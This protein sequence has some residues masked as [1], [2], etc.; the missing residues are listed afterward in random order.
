MSCATQTYNLGV[1]NVLFGAER[2]QKHCIFTVKDTASSLNNKYIVMHAPVTNA[3]HYFWFNTGAGADP[4]VP[5]A[6]GHEVTITANA[7]ASAVATALQGVIDPLAFCSATVS[8]NEVEVTYTTYGYAYN[9]RDGFTTNATGFTIQTPVFGSTQVDL[10]A[11]DGEIS[12]SA[13]PEYLA[14]PDPRYGA[15]N[16]VDLRRGVSD[17][18][19]SFDLKDSSAAINAELLTAVF[20]ASVRKSES[21]FNLASDETR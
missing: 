2:Y 18:S 16:V 17:A 19:A 7:S 20:N 4:A 21:R 3:K 10:G 14:V 13:T 15:Y 5:N 8:T 9:A 11:T 1:M 6:T 12:F